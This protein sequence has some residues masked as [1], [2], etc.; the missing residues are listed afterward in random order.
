MQDG[1]LAQLETERFHAADKTTLIMPHRRQRCGDGR[2]LPDQLW[3]GCILPDVHFDDLRNSCGDHGSYSPHRQGIF[4][5]RLAENNAANLRK[6]PCQKGT[7]RPCPAHP[8][9]CACMKRKRHLVCWRQGKLHG[10]ISGR[11]GGLSR[12]AHQKD[13]RP[14]R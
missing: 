14:T 11:R 8:A 4:V 6:A 3:P 7:D 9:R 13:F 5:A 10:K 2:V 12:F 1:F